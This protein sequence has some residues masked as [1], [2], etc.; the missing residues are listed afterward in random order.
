MDFNYSTN[1]QV[2]IA[3]KKG[4]PERNA[5]RGARREIDGE[6]MISGGLLATISMQLKEGA[7][8]GMR[9]VLS[10]FGKKVGYRRL[11]HRDATGRCCHRVSNLDL[12]HSA[13]NECLND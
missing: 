6:F 1:Y 11:R 10:F 9:W 12:S 13:I 4:A 2:T 3:L 8:S 7:T 5:L